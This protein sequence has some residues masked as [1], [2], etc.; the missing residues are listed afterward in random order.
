MLIFS[1]VLNLSTYHLT[2]NLYIY[3]VQKEFANVLYESF[4]RVIHCIMK[5]IKLFSESCVL[6]ILSTVY[7]SYMYWIPPYVLSTAKIY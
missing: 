4:T 1:N 3:F 2:I 6:F 5:N 7:C